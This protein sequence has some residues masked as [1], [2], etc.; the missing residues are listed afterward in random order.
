M[1][2]LTYVLK[3]GTDNLGKE[4]II[5]TV[6]D[7]RASRKFPLKVEMFI[8]ISLMVSAYVL[9]TVNYVDGFNQLT[10]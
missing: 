4:W 2:V 8:V 3:G 6:I 5:R 1:N 10:N 9:S 7:S